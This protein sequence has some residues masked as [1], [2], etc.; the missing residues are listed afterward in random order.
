M[1]E[2]KIFSRPFPGMDPGHEQFCEISREEFTGLIRRIS[3][4]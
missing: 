1:T 2:T 4:E 3:G